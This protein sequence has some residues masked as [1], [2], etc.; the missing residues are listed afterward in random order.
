MT[1]LLTELREMNLLSEL[2][3]LNS[4]YEFGHTAPVD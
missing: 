1:V 2:C 4:M 3:C